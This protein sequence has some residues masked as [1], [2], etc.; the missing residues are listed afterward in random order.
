MSI[1]GVVLRGYSNGSFSGSIAEVSTRGY[2][3]SSAP[4]AGV[5]RRST[6]HVGSSGVSG[7]AR[8]YWEGRRKQEDLDL[9][10]IITQF[11]KDV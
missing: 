3:P 7:E 1:A 6:D 2:I 9:M 8:I 4:P 11:L 5:S 10:T